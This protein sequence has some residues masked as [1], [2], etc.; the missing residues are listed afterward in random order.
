[1]LL[2]WKLGVEPRRARKDAIDAF[3]IMDDD[4]SWDHVLTVKIFRRGREK[5]TRYPECRRLNLRMATYCQ[6]CR[7]LVT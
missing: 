1:M 6:G 4:M 5:E 3:C 2:I 7:V